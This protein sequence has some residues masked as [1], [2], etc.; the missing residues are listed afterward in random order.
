MK[1]TEK[2]IHLG[3]SLKNLPNRVRIKTKENNNM[4][5][6]RKKYEA[7]LEKARQETREE[8]WKENEM[9]RLHGMVEELKMKVERLSPMGKTCDGVA[10][11]SCP[12]PTI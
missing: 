8:M 1:D 7:D 4:F 5:I 6:S 3:I 9:N 12:G 11:G 2:C 10:H